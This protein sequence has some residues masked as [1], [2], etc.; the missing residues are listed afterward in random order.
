MDQDNQ[1]KIQNEAGEQNNT[2]NKQLKNNDIKQ[3]RLTWILMGIVFIV[4]ISRFAYVVYQKTV[5]LNNARKMGENIINPVA[6]QKPQ[7]YTDI[8]SL[9]ENKE[10]EKVSK[11]DYTYYLN[12]NIDYPSWV[13]V[14]YLNLKVGGFNLG[15]YDETSTSI[16]VNGPSIEKIEDAGAHIVIDSI[17]TINGPEDL[18]KDDFENNVPDFNNRIYDYE[19]IGP[20]YLGYRDLKISSKLKEITK[21]T[22]RIIAPLFGKTEHVEVAEGEKSRTIDFGKLSKIEFDE[23]TFLASYSGNLEYISSV[24][25]DKDGNILDGTNYGVSNGMIF[26]LFDGNI[27]KVDMTFGAKPEYIEIPFVWNLKN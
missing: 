12:Y 18:S 8:K 14:N 16:Y 2:G 10:F 13:L 26:S 19:E 17:D 21:I 3:R 9:I 24:G 1:E 23:H 20:Y 11:E 5:I 25:Y 15:F 7:K 27:Y 6:D 22:G 4:A